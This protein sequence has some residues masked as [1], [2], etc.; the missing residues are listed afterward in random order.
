MIVARANATD[1]NLDR[2]AFSR[3]RFAVSAEGAG[4]RRAVLPARPEVGR[5]IDDCR[6]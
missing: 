1:P 5:V 4:L 2:L 3:G 6:R